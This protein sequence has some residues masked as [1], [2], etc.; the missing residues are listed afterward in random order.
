MLE[1][2]EICCPLCDSKKYEVLYEPWV[3]ELD[4]LKLYGAGTGV[5]GTQRLVKCIACG[6]IYENPRYPED[7]ILKGYISTNESLHDSQYENRVNS[8][9]K[10]MMKLKGELPPK[11]AKVLDIGTA[12]GAFLEAGK[13]FGYEVYG[14]EPSQFL[15]REGKKRGLNIYQG[16]I[17][18]HPFEENTF[19]MVCLWDVLEHLTEPKQALTKIRKLLKREGV[20]LINYPDIGT[21]MAKLFGRR[22]WWIVSTHLIHFDRR[23]ITKICEVTGYKVFHFSP[24]YQTLDLGYL[25]EM[26]IRYNV[27]LAKTISD[28]LPE[29]I[30]K[31]TVP[32][33]AS[34]TT[35]LARLI[36]G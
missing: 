15:V 10:T 32:Y 26:A 6:L 27:P 9:Y 23:T 12:G 22:F 8:F 28:V 11:G 20:L 7:I 13:R 5:Q 29:F 2:V 4:P 31:I 30:K 17:N 21:F 16:T 33:Y 35:A 3:N 19:D 34:Q 14:L 25:F 36:N 1:K 24:Y 18:D